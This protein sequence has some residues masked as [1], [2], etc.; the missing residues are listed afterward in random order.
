M[1]DTAESIESPP[2][3][4]ELLADLP[5]AGDLLADLRWRGLVAQSTDEAALAA[6][7]A[8]GP[9]TLYCGFDPTAP[10][11]HVG[12]LVPL[13]TL[14]RFQ[15]AGHR[16]IGLV[17]GATG[18][19]G[20]P[21]GRSAERSLQD[22]DVVADW[23]ALIRSQLDLV[24]DFDGPAP[25]RV[26]SNLD[27]TESLSAIEL[28]RDVG[29]HFSV[30]TMLAKES[31]ATRLAENGI[32]Y[33]EFSYMILQAYDF[34][35]LYRSADCR[36][37]I[38]GA[39]QWGNITAG[40]D[41]IRRV[42]G[43][44]STPAHALTVPL[45]VKSDGAKFG[46]TAGGAIWLDAK[47]TSPYAF[48]QFWLNTDDRDVV[49]FL[50]LFSLR[51][52]S[53]ISQII[54]D[55]DDRRASRSAQRALAD[56]LTTLIHGAEETVRVI[57]AGKALFGQGD[58]AQLDAATLDAALAEAPHVV[59]AAGEPTPTVVDLLVATGLCESKGAA[60]RAI[61]EGGAYLDNV[62]V[63]DA[64]TVPQATLAGGWVLLRKGKRNLAGVR[65]PAG[66]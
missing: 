50:R 7:L 59:I 12:N 28:L 33:T 51:T 63:L 17:G 21:S 58:L 34:L 13:L 49:R 4:G 30:N 27:W 47:M 66:L 18:L 65:L 44:G 52:P 5:A 38:G 37:Q 8:Q 64:D 60:R 45:V 54:A 15:L 42:E 22:T 23:L 19:I 3:A 57:A 56:E 61:K 1:T 31:V 20:D 35:E 2:A 14:R 9:I 36:L 16:P 39:D 32:S 43:R 40:L 10:S 24:L 62:R 11:L 25:A 29:K 48:H 41:L 46:K 53:E 6:A 55:W 26:V